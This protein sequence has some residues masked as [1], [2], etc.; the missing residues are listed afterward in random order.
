MFILSDNPYI[1]TTPSFPTAKDRTVI[2]VLM[3]QPPSFFQKGHRW[4]T[5]VLMPARAIGN[6]LAACL[7]LK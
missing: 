5:T 4:D 3:V 7:V 6:L 2:K 1:Q